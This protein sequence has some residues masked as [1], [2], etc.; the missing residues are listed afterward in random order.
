MP[1]P[2][3]NLS[4]IEMLNVSLF[5]V[6]DVREYSEA[7]LAGGGAAS[8][9]AEAAPAGQAALAGPQAGVVL[10]IVGITP[11]GGPD[12]TQYLNSGLIDKLRKDER[13]IRLKSTSGEEE[14]L[15]KIVRLL[16]FRQA[17]EY[18]EFSGRAAAS[19]GAAG[20]AAGYDKGDY[21]WFEAVWVV[22]TSDQV[23]AA[24]APEAGPAGAPKPNP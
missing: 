20:A 9:P 6:P 2:R 16:P 12:A 4:I 8:P 10:R 18:Q 24:A 22:R 14:V 1:A 23:K 15:A 7:S 13:T 5:Y 3:A 19:P 11:K 17:L 21:S